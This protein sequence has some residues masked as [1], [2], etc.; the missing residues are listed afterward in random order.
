M[1]KDFEESWKELESDLE[2][3]FGKLPDL[4]SIIYLIGINEVGFVHDRKFT[5]EQKQDLMHVA[6]CIL[7]SQDE[8]Y[9]FDKNDDDGWPHFKL[10]RE[11]PDYDLIRQEQWLK[12]LI[13]RY[14]AHN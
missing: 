11:L 1:S 4:Q 13:V 8:Y 14:F 6:T 5:K 7:L 9:V 12:E 10:I 3:R 2:V